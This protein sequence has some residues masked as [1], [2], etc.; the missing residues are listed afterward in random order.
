M[1]LIILNQF[2]YPDHSATSQLMTDLA[3]SLSEKGL[4]VTAL[5]GRGRYNGG[6]SLPRRELYGGVRIERAW[7]TSF[8]KESVAGRLIDYLSFYLGACWKLLTLPRHD[9][10]MALT[11]PPLISLLALLVC[12]LRGMKLVALVQDIYPDVAVSLGTLKP[13]GFL[14]R[15]LDLFSCFTLRK[16]DR[17]VVLSDC[18]REKILCKVGDEIRPRLDVIHNWAD[19]TKI[20]PLEEAAPN[21]FVETHH[22]VNKFVVLFSGNL[23]RVNDFSTILDAARL[24][25]QRSDIRFLFIGDGAKALEIKEFIQKH[26]LENINLLPYQPRDLLHLSL[27]AGHAHLVTLAEG[28]AGLSV[29]SKAYGIL[30]S[31]RP[32]IFVGD[33][34]S[35][36]AK[37]ISENSCGAVVAAGESERLASI[38]AEWEANRDSLKLMGREARELFNSRFDRPLAVSAYLE[39]FGKCISE[40]PALMTQQGQSSITSAK[41]RN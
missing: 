2:F 34:K 9:I 27:A 32:I 6:E 41:Q 25:R 28:L 38:I 8:G 33:S 31:G 35:D 40:E 37:F 21:R 15:I 4:Q 13:D 19:G 12:R 18:M 29:P 22:L 14:T 26:R 10:V 16:A 36:V 39:S 24:L 3:Q 5:A 20:K 7:A 23:G 11:T 17:V 30:A 1:R